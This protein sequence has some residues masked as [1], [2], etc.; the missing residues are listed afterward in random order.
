MAITTYAELQTAI[1]NWNGGRTDVASRL[2]EYI[3]LAEAK[4][5]RR[6]RTKDMVTKNAAFSI[7]G[8]YVATPA[9]FGGVKTFYL[10]TDPK[11]TLEHMADEVMTDLYPSGTG[12]PRFYNVQ[13]SNFRFAPVPD[14]TYTA[15]LVYWLQVP[16]LSN[17]NTT[18]WLLTSHPDAY[19]YGAMG[20]I[21]GYLRD[22][23]G[24][25]NWEAML[26]Q[27]LDEIASSSKRD[28]GGNATMMTR[29]A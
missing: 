23:D 28:L 3:A 1:T 16:A 13:G 12:V 17:S 27:I 6:L 8:E 4:M 20:E 2:T 21:C 26:Y 22:F 10:N 7:D 5:N 24:A 15:T 18:N 11:R 9:S 14:G 25:K 19:L 29:P